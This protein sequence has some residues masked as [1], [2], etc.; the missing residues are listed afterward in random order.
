VKREQHG[1]PPGPAPGH[2]SFRAVVT[3]RV[4]GVGFRYSAVRQ[5]RAL[6]LQGVVSNRFDGSVEVEAEGAQAALERFLSWLN[7]GP[8]GAHVGG[9]QVEWLPPSGRFRDFEVDF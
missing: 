6:G 4:Q 7:Q 2:A 1:S 3:G 9:V 8:P 5:A